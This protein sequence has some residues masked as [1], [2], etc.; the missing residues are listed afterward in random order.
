M[1]YSVIIPVGACL[2]SVRQC[3]MDDFEVLLIDDGSTDHTFEV[4]RGYAEKDPRIIVFQQKNQGPSVARNFGLKRATGKYVLFLDSDDFFTNGVFREITPVLNRTHCDLAVSNMLLFD[5][6]SK[7]YVGSTDPHI[8]GKNISN[9]SQCDVLTYLGDM[10]VS[11]SPCRY[12]IK[13]EVLITNE[14]LFEYGI[15]HEDTLWMP[16]MLCYCES[17]QYI[18]TPFYNI[19][20]RSVSRGKLNRSKRI[21][22]LYKILGQLDSF[23]NGRISYQQQ[24]LDVCLCVDTVFLAGEVAEADSSVKKQ[25]RKWFHDH[26]N[27]IDR[28]KRNRHDIQ[29]LS[30]VVGNYNAFMLHSYILKLRNRLVNSK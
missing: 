12:V 24:F 15:Q 6:T 22:S 17:F 27:M 29:L 19:R 2:E 16:M 25:A 5:D 30:A 23:R 20:M 18:S 21:S 3:G 10:R 4:A 13:R 28:I 26:Q 9:C 8:S 11:P 1:K 7:K 14:L